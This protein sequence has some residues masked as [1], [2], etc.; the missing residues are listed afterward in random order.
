MLLLRRDTFDCAPFL[1]QRLPTS[2]VALIFHAQGKDATCSEVLKSLA[3]FAP[4]YEYPDM[5]KILMKDYGLSKASV[6]RYLTHAPDTEVRELELSVPNRLPGR[7]RLESRR[8]A[9][10]PPTRHANEL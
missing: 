3:K 10:V 2:R 4:G 5:I 6:Y 8:C 1:E 9:P 7:S